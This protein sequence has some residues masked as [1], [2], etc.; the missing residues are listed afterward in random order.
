MTS[1]ELKNKALEKCFEN[2]NTEQRIAVFNTN[3]PQLILAGAGSGKTTVLINRIVYMIFFGD[4]YHTDVVQEFSDTEKKFLENYIS[5]KETDMKMLS[6]IIGYD[7]I[8]PYNIFAITFT[9]KAAGELKDRIARRLG[10]RGRLVT[11]STFHSACAKILRRD[12]NA[13]RLGF[14]NSFTIYDADDSKIVIK[15]LMKE[16]GIDDKLL[17]YRDVM[18]AIS[19]AKDNLIP[20]EKFLDDK[21]D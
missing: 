10:E 21:K 9:N 12:R 17:P 13:E 15:V 5:G 18:V 11:A 16:K 19:H 4:A 8:S 2:M 14:K 3:G 6:D 7:T 1:N 20:P